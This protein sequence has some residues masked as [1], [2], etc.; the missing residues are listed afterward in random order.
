MKSSSCT[1]L[2]EEHHPGGGDRLQEGMQETC[3][4]C[5]GDTRVCGGAVSEV[6]EA[7]E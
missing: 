6:S 2:Q 5:A 1:S 7:K 3:E 4:Q